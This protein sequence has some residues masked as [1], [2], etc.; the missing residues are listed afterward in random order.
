MPLSS[1][2]GQAIPVP[3]SS[4]AFLHQEHMSQSSIDNFNLLKY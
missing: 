1:T 2:A 4:S 3:V